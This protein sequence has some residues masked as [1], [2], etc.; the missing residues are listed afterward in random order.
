MSPNDYSD[1]LS[2][3]RSY[4]GTIMDVMHRGFDCDPTHR[5]RREFVTTIM[6]CGSSRPDLG[7]NQLTNCISRTTFIALPNEWTLA[8]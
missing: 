4:S 2:T 6:Q 3:P 8:S 7:G 1:N 5:K